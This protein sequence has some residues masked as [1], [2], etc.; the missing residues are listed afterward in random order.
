MLTL[1]AAPS[2][3]KINCSKFIID[4]FQQWCH[5]TLLVPLFVKL[6]DLLFGVFLARK[7]I[8]ILRKI[9]IIFRQVSLKGIL[10]SVRVL[11]YLAVKS[12][13][14]I[15]EKAKSLKNFITN[16]LLHNWLSRFPVR[17]FLSIYGSLFVS[18]VT[19]IFC[20]RIHICKKYFFLLSLFLRWKGKQ[21]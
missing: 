9:T 15:Y 7:T 2:K 6:R 1:I 8:A 4:G 3:V 21:K 13:K 17:F 20:V 19:N 5:M 14:R 16:E 10:L 12:F 18:Y 11:E